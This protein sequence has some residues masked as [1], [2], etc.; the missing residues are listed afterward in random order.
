MTPDPAA[1]PDGWQVVRL[2]DVAEVVCGLSWTREQESSSPVAGAVPVVRIGNVQPDGFHMDDI[3]WV[4]GVAES[5]RLRRAISPRTLVM[6]GSNGNRDRVGNVFLSD[7]RLDGHLLASFLIA[8]APSQGTS[9]QFLAALL[10][11]ERTQS[12]ITASTAGSTGLKN[13]SLRWLRKLRLELPPLPEQ[14]AIAAVLDA[15]DEEIER[16]EE[17][18]AATERLRD[19]L[20]YEL[21]TRGLPGWHSEWADVP[22]LG[23][24]PACWDVVRLQEIA[25]VVG[26]ST[27]PPPAVC[28]TIGVVTS[29]GS[30]HQN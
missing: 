24:V 3:L 15:I 9:E 14:R 16:T 10:R 25:E 27:P 7:R 19:A 17:V 23:T 21:L 11:S 4:R 2:G 20:L 18:I 6:V 13:L 29:P 12:R 5:E 8:V 22:G 26:G 1:V 30:C 28:R